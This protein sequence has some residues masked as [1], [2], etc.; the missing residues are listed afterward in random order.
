[1][2]SEAS[3]TRNDTP[4]GAQFDIVS[5]SQPMGRGC[6]FVGVYAIC[7]VMILLGATFGMLVGLP[8]LA[9]TIFMHVK[10]GDK[11]S[12]APT[13]LVVNASGITVGGKFYPAD[14][15]VQLLLRHPND[16][17][18]ANYEIQHKSDAAHV[19]AMVRTAQMNRS[20]ALMARL[21]A[22]ST[23]EVL[24]FGLTPNTG[25]ALL[26]DVTRELNLS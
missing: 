1:V 13:R 6:L 25:N 3:F 4:E 18:G 20:Y 17:G 9:F 12:R 16:T 24:V 22:S 14:S 7:A 15:I 23:P 21:K 5:A 2:A 26:N 8:L 19:G 10:S 11:H